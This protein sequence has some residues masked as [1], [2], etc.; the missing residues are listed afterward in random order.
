MTDTVFS[1]IGR[2]STERYSRT[3]GPLSRILWTDWSK[4]TRTDM[5]EAVKTK[6]RTQ[7]GHR[8]YMSQVLPE[9]KGFIKAG[10]SS[11]EM[12]PKIAQ[13]KASL[14]EQL[15]SLRTVDVE[16]LSGLVEQEGVTD[17][18]IA[19]KVQIAGNLK[20]EIKAITRP[21]LSFLRQNQKVLWAHI[22]THQLRVAK[23]S[24]TTTCEQSFPS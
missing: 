15:E 13:L 12:W 19:E 18:E 4:Q 9:A 23:C 24:Q 10:E 7:G 22:Q 2:T 21:W 3:F 16:I 1:L 6:R 20:G 8:A 17:K 5:G 11:T 14:E